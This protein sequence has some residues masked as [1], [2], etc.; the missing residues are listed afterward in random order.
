[1]RFHRSVIHILGGFDARELTTNIFRGA[2]GGQLRVGQVS[3]SRASVRRSIN[4][5]P[6]C[7]SFGS[8]LPNSWIVF[9][10]S[11]SVGEEYRHRAARELI[12]VILR[13]F[14]MRLGVERL[15]IN[16]VGC[17]QIIAGADLN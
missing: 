12:H 5:F 17:L 8:F 15:G 4:S 11:L 9:S 3:L 2:D 14:G 13:V 1:M 10:E 7:A 6:A 16:E